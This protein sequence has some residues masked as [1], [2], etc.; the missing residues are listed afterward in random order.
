MFAAAGMVAA[1]E[2]FIA[3]VTGPIGGEGDRQYFKIGNYRNFVP[4]EAQLDFDIFWRGEEGPDFD[5][6]FR[7]KP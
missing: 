4:G 5:P 2:R 7:P 3:R 1:N 6:D